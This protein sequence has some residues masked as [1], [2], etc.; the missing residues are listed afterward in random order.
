MADNITITLMQEGPYSQSP[1]AIRTKYPHP[2]LLYE[3]DIDGDGETDIFY[4]DMAIKN[5]R[6]VRLGLKGAEVKLTSNGYQKTI[7]LVN[8]QSID[9]WGVTVYVDGQAMK[10]PDKLEAIVS[11]LSKERTNP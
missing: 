8:H 6:I 7:D 4:V 11:T 10:A 2:S 3:G 9:Q 5:S 1:E